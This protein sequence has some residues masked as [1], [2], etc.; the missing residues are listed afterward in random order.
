MN[1]K[2][3]YPFDNYGIFLVVLSIPSGAS[4][5][6]D[7][8][9]YEGPDTQQIICFYRMRFPSGLENYFFLKTSFSKL[10]TNWLGE[11]MRHLVCFVHPTPKWCNFYD[12]NASKIVIFKFVEVTQNTNIAPGK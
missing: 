3:L 4:W 8:T 7:L 10:S 5:S 9:L 11:N 1:T 12:A 6:D 2:Y